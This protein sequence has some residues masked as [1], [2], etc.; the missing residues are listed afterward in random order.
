MLHETERSARQ[1]HVFELPTSESFNLAEP[2]TYTPTSALSVTLPTNKAVDVLAFH[3][4]ASSL[5]LASSQ[6]TLSVFDVASQSPA[7]AYTLSSPSPSWS[8]Q[9]SSDGRS[10]TATG[11]DGQFRC[12]DVRASAAAPVLQVVASHAGHKASR[13]VHLGLGLGSG[14]QVLTTGFSRTRDREYS[15][16]D[17]RNLGSGGGGAVKTQRVDTGTGVLVPLADQSRG[18]VYLAGKGDMTLRW[19]ELGGPGGF[20]E[21]RSWSSPPLKPPLFF[22]S[23]SALRRQSPQGLTGQNP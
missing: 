11:K 16:L 13:H 8:A 10:V 20:T 22:L 14:S 18:I 15:V 2:G 4:L 7:A 5:F 3:P 21:G 12:W 19:T 6:T 23:G 9:W 17:L 1:V